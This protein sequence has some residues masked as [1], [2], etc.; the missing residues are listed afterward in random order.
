MN[1]LNGLVGADM[2]QSLRRLSSVFLVC[3][4][5]L[6]MAF[7]AQAQ[8]P[9]PKVEKAGDAIL[10]MDYSNSMWGQ[11]EGTAKIQIARDIIERNFD[12]WNR[13]PWPALSKR[14]PLISKAPT[15]KP[16]SF[17]LPMAS[18]AVIATPVRRLKPC[19]RKV[20]T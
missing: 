4:G 13:R 8:L 14:Q 2:W 3:F 9:A 12:D 18:R 10:I 15:R 17:C 1:F 7:G 16:T 20:S 5:L 11:I 19:R 6:G